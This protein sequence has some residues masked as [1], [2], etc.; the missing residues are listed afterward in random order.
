MKRMLFLD[1]SQERHDALDEQMAKD[2]DWEAVHVYTAD[3]AIK[4]IN[5]NSYEIV[6]LDHDLSRETEMMLPELGEK[7]GYDVAVHIANMP[8]DTRPKCVIVHSWNPNGA[9]RMMKAMEGKVSKLKYIP[10]RP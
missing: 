1:D 4:L 3:E 9:D 5:T 6:S 8:E 2:W 10:F 7:S